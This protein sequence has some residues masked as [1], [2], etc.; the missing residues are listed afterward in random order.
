MFVQDFEK[1]GLK[2][3]GV[4][5]TKKEQQQPRDILAN[6]GTEYDREKKRRQCLESIPHYPFLN[7]M[8]GGWREQTYLLTHLP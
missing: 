8:G 4:K 3:I 7:T 5:K 1:G 2:M 6:M